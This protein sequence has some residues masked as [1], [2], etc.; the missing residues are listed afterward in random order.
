MNP[1]TVTTY[2]QF[3]STPKGAL[4]M[5]RMS[6][7]VNVIEEFYRYLEDSGQTIDPLGHLASSMNLSRD[8]LVRQIDERSSDLDFLVELAHRSG[9]ELKIMFTKRG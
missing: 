5:A 9:A 4:T 8:E 6:A 1:K 7:R 2:E 3:V